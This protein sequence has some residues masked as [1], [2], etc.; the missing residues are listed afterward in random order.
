MNHFR[1]NGG[2]RQ[3]PPMWST[4]RICGR[5]RCKFGESQ[6]MS[7]EN[8]QV[9]CTGRKDAETTAK[10]HIFQQRNLPIIQLPS[11]PKLLL[12]QFSLQKCHPTSNSCS[13]HHPD[14]SGAVASLGSHL[15]CFGRGE[16]RGAA[17]AVAC[18]G[19]CMGGSGAMG[20]CHL[21]CNLCGIGWVGE[22][23][24]SCMH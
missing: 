10:Y 13:S 2:A 7:K 11:F 3:V 9:S 15:L 24:A 6:V 16:F 23:C 1:S 12:H 14:H 21:G 19:R 18:G 8:S 20:C 17:A 22:A 4:G 5:C